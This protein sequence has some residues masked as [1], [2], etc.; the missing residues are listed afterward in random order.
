M[1]DGQSLFIGRFQPLHANHI[2]LIRSL[3]AEGKKVCVAMMNTKLDGENPYTLDERKEMF[4]RAFGATVTVVVIPAISEVCY[5]R[6]VGYGLRELS[7]DVE[8]PEISGTKVREVES[9]SQINI[10]SRA[11]FAR[12]LRKFA[13][14]QHADTKRAGFWPDHPRNPSEALMGIVSE[15]G[16]VYEA[17]RD[18][19]LQDKDL[20][21]YTAASV[22]LGDV[23]MRC[24]DLAEG[25]GWTTIEAMPD[26]MLYNRQRPYKH[27]KEF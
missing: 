11:E 18:G 27:G 1:Q 9:A 5:G 23:I 8:I 26:K 7:L 10:N 24:L 22:Q 14:E 16:E 20:S 4:R 17:L 2:A 25:Q 15:V 13:A 3:L 19:N 12:V 6:D 21:Q